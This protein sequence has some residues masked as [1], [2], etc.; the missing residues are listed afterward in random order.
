MMLIHCEGHARRLPFN[1]LH[2]CQVQHARLDMHGTPTRL[3]CSPALSN[4]AQVPYQRTYILKL[5][6]E[7]KEG[8]K[9]RGQDVGDKAANPQEAKPDPSEFNVNVGA[10]IMPSSGVCR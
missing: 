8:I 4:A 9:P 6:A 7:E 1:S 5:I 3:A 2:R 10:R